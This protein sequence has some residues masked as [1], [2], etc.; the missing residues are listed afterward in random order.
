MASEKGK[1]DKEKL[2]REMELLDSAMALNRLVKK[3]DLEGVFITNPAKDSETISDDI[4]DRIIDNLEK[5]GSSDEGKESKLIRDFLG[6]AKEGAE[7]AKHKNKSTRRQKPSER[8]QVA[9]KKAKIKKVK[10]R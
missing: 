8:K 1:K 3:N 5:A 2:K 9:P 7:E 10:R 6:E 4:S